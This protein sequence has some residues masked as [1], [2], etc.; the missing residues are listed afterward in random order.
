MKKPTG[1]NEKKDGDVEKGIRILPSRKTN[2]NQPGIKLEKTID[3]RKKDYMQRNRTRRKKEMS[4]EKWSVL[5]GMQPIKILNQKMDN[6]E[7]EQ[8]NGQDVA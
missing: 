1:T 2:L 7:G 8:V 4:K 5:F 3:R 6:N